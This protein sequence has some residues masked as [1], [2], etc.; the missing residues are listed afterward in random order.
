MRKCSNCCSDKTY[1]NQWTRGLCKKCYNKL[2]VHPKWNPIHNK[3]Y[4]P[5]HMRWTPTG[6]QILVNENP[7]IGICNWCCAVVGVN[8]KRTAIHHFGKY[9][10]EDPL[11][12]TIEL[13]ESCHNKAR[14]G[15]RYNKS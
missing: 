2:V 4:N 12:D 13:C 11:R 9:H 1:R 14:I 10:D 5:R 6:K 8:C 3:I 15:M 7:R